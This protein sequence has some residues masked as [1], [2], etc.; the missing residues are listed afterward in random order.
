MFEVKLYDELESGKNLIE[1]FKELNKNK[2]VPNGTVEIFI[3]DEILANE[4]SRI[5][6][7]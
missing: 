6:R 5:V 2:T 7:L 3:A 1:I 4:D